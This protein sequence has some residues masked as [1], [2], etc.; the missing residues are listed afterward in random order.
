MSAPDH[1]DVAVIQKRLKTACRKLHELAPEV[2]MARQIISFDSDRRKNLLARYTV[3]HIKDGESVAASET[4]ARADTAY[5]AELSGLA[6][7]LTQA[8]TTLRQY[9][10]ERCSWESARSLLSMQRETMKTLPGTED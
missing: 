7:V 8:E 10:A 1:S 2:G 4:L 5:E 9:E 3:K 6:D